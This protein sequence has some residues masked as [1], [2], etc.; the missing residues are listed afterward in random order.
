MTWTQL[1]TIS[2]GQDWQPTPIISSHLGYV[3]LT[4]ETAGVPV[5]IAQCDP[6]SSDIYDE[7]RILATTH[8]R[9]LEF[10]APPF[11]SD[12]ALALRVPSFSTP[13]EIQIEVSTV[14]FISSG[15]GTFTPIQ[16]IAASAAVTDVDASTQAVELLAANANRKKLIVINNSTAT[17][18][19]A[20]GETASP[21]NHT[22]AI[23]NDGDG[24]ELSDFT[25]IVSAIWTEATGKARV[26]EFS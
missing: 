24:Y 5:W 19:L 17:M 6:D 11:F 9:I 14:P 23:T 7:R 26:T 2:V 13:F 15:G 1:T 25:G 12:R 16:S 4:F 21:T 18:Y 3:R 8:P 10:A 20:F 22:I